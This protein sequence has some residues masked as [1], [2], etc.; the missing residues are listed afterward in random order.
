MLFSARVIKKPKGNGISPEG[1]KKIGA[2][3]AL[4]CNFFFALCRSLL[5]FFGWLC[6]LPRLLLLHSYIFFMVVISTFSPPL[7]PAFEV[8]IYQGSFYFVQQCHLFVNLLLLGFYE[9][10]F[11]YILYEIFWLYAYSVC[12]FLYY[13]LKIRYSYKWNN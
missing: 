12:L 4:P 1:C 11:F 10:Y 2:N 9:L 6:A 5:V 13:L 7:T 8:P 3:L